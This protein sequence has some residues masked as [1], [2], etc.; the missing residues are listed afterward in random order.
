MRG[1]AAPPAAD[2]GEVSGA[3]GR[4]CRARPGGAMGRCDPPTGPGRGPT[5][6]AGRVAPEPA[7]SAG[8]GREYQ[9]GDD[10]LG[11]SVRSR[12]GTAKLQGV[13]PCKLAGPRRSCGRALQGKC[14]RLQGKS[15]RELVELTL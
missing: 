6:S 14:S 2:R 13:A 8:V 10:F 12:R 1:A 11:C 7:K 5:A 15:S 9:G 3:L 4:R